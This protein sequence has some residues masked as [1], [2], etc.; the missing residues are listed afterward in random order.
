MW[1]DNDIDQ[2]FQRLNPPEPEPTPFP[3]DGWLQ[4]ETRLDQAVI[5]RA[6]RRK[7]WRV[8][9]A[10]V[11]V[12]VLAALGWL[13]WPGRGAAPTPPLGGP[14]AAPA[15]PALAPGP[16]HSA[17]SPARTAPIR[18]TTAPVRVAE[19]GPAAGAAAATA[20]ASAAVAP[21]MPVL[22]VAAD[23]VSPAANNVPAPSANRVGKPPA[24]APRGSAPVLACITKAQQA[25]I[26]K[27][28]IEVR[29]E[30]ARVLSYFGVHALKDIPATDYERVIRSLEK[31]RNAAA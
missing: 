14:A 18:P 8:F 31:R 28:A 25:Q 10:E 5:A 12:V 19:H 30:L 3:L 26:H 13:L 9:A 24:R 20:V 29:I 15:T 23:V 7:L 11:A 1:S 27:L 6:V 4:L 22:P 21:V 17:F 2:A 16:G